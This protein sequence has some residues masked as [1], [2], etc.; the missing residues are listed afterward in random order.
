VSG[1][2]FIAR[3]AGFGAVVAIAVAGCSSGGD[4]ATPRPTPSASNAAA[5]GSVAGTSLPSRSGIRLNA[6]VRIG[7]ATFRPVATSVTPA[8]SPL[9]AAHRAH[10]HMA[11][12]TG[13]RR[14]TVVYL[15]ALTQSAFG[16]RNTLAYGY[17]SAASFAC[18]LISSQ[19]GSAPEPSPPN[20]HCRS[21]SFVNA[22]TGDRLLGVTAPATITPLA[23]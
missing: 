5:S 4:Q 23:G 14:G 22:N 10:P 20:H 11:R 19:G 15:G 21:W 3:T 8:L 2:R 13:L 16:F 7:L 9:Q 6:P 12:L 18:E 17:T 1:G